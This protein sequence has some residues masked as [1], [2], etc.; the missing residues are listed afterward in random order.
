M[1]NLTSL[2]A[3]F[4]A[5]VLA[6]SLAATAN[7][8]QF[9]DVSGNLPALGASTEASKF[10]DWDLD[11]DLDLVYSNGGDSNNQQ[12]RLLFNRGLS[13]AGG[14]AL[15]TIGT[16]LDRTSTNLL[17]NFTT[18]GRDVQVEDM[19]NDGDLDFYFSNHSQSTTQSNVFFT[20]MGGAQGGTLGIY[21]LQPTRWNGVGLAGSSVPAAQKITGGNFDNG[22]QD[23]SCQCD[24]ADVDLDGDLDLYHT[25]YGSGFNANVMSRL[26]L[27]GFGTAVGRFTEYNPSGQVSANPNIAAGSAAGFLEGTHSNN[28]AN[29]SGAQHDITNMSLDADFADLDGDFDN[30]IHANSRDTRQRMYQNRYFENGGTLGNEGSNTRLYRDVTN[31]WIPSLT[32]ASSNYDSDLADMDNDNDVDGYWLNGLGGTT[33]GWSLNNGSGVFG[34]NFTV[35]N[36]GNDDNEVDWLD[37]DNDSDVDPY[38][39]AFRGADKFYRNQFIETGSVNLVQVTIHSGSG[40]STLAADPGDMDNDGD[41]DIIEAQ[42]AGGNEVLLRNNL[43]VPDPHA[44]RLPN[45][46]ALVASAPTSAKRRVVVRVFDNANQENFIHATGVLNFTV[47]GSPKQVPAKYAGGNLWLAFIPG[48]WTGTISYTMSVTDRA[49]NTGTSAANVVVIPQAGV[50]L[51]GTD[52]PGCTGAHVISTNSAPTINNPDFQFLSTKCPPSSLG[53][54]LYAT[55]AWIGNDPFGIGFNLWVD[56]FTSIEIGT[57]DIFTDGAG[58][59]VGPAPIPNSPILIGQQYRL[60]GLF[61]ETA[62][63]LPPFNLSGTQG[64]TIT[65][66]P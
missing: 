19:D 2:S 3:W 20:N 35:P 29:T 50:S 52:Q 1:R 46:K 64:M 33:D 60:Q 54:G 32:D 26:F 9:T 34:A 24:F 13:S 30:D 21:Q 41:L 10:G 43:N 62:C 37:Y 59:G 63:S 39:S 61:V 57:F 44:P 17:P 25:S 55:N 18:S 48:Y 65:I 23:W 36:S 45:V 38:V 66:Q 5:T 6:A 31:A 56:L 40:T 53:L 15:G 14:G 28:T 7:A 4:T 47:N 42:D 27:N 12:D 51:F 58:N 11:G 16:F 22:F 49:G 8:Q